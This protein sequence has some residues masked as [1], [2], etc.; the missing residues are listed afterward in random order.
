M[1]WNGWW[2]ADCGKILSISDNLFFR[3]IHRHVCLYGSGSNPLIMRCFD[4]GKVLIV[5]S[6]NIKTN[7]GIMK[8]LIFRKT[9][10]LAM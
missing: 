1:C 5:M 7:H 6:F 10:R 9:N 8:G 2:T 4:I 3:S